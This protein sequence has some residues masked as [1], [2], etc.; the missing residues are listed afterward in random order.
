MHILTTGAGGHLGCKLFHLLE[1][2]EQFTV[3]GLDMRP[4]DHPGTQVANLSGTP[5]WAGYL[6]GVEAIV[7]LA[8]DGEPTASWASSVKNNMDATLTLCHHAARMGL[9][10]VVL[11]SSNWL[12]GDKRF[13]DDALNGDT[14][15]GPINPYGMSKIF[16]GHTGAYFAEYYNLSVICLRIGWTQL[17]HHNQPGTHMAMGRW[18]QEMWLSDRDFLAGV[19]SAITVLNV[20]FATVDLVS[21]NLGMRWDLR[22]ANELIGSVPQDESRASLNIKQRFQ[23]LSK[24]LVVFILPRWFERKFP[25]CDMGIAGFKAMIWLTDM[26]HS[27][28]SQA[29]LGGKYGLRS[30]CCRRWVFRVSF[31]GS[32]GLCWR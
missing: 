6:E 1:A 12:H 20:K 11:T 24:K 5:V 25:S 13:T 2:D 4:V 18:G 15:S 7:H 3:S 31:G 23:S 28:F 26:L 17:A 22:E 27:R 9:S 32:V 10:H 14:P 30:H 29:S 19:K 8:G 16:C 21:D